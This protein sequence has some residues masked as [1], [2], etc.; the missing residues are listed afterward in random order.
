MIESQE[1]ENIINAFK[2][3]VK[4]DDLTA[5]QEKRISDT[6]QASIEWVRGFVLPFLFILRKFEANFIFSSFLSKFALNF[7]FPSSKQE[8]QAT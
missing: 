1:I 2:K 8:P 6:Q 3:D 5:F 7:K 4:M